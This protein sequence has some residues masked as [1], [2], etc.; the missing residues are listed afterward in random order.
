MTLDM[1]V[2]DNW[3]PVLTIKSCQLQFLSLYLY[4]VPNDY[5]IVTL[6][7]HSY[8]IDKADVWYLNFVGIIRYGKQNHSMY[9][10]NTRSAMQLDVL[11]SS[12]MSL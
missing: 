12:A 11:V 10:T 1:H 6:T 2:V 7:L 4:A 5:T 3:K 9:A 8:N